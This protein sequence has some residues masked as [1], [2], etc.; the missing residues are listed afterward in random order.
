MHASGVPLPPSPPPTSIT[1]AGVRRGIVEITPFAPL[2][3]PMGKAY[4][5]AA[6]Q[7]GIEPWLATLTSL[8]TCAGSVQFAVL[9]LWVSPPTSRM[10]AS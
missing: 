10:P 8:L 2:V 4:G 5:M 3:G 7:G 1:D 6:S 9:D